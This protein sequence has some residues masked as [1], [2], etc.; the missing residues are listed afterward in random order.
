MHQ[1]QSGAVTQLKQFAVSTNNVCANEI[2]LIES[3][4]EDS[5]MGW[6][7]MVADAMTIEQLSMDGA[8]SLEGAQG[9]TCMCVP[10]VM[11]LT[12]LCNHCRNA[13]E[14]W[15]SDQR[16]AKCSRFGRRSGLVTLRTSRDS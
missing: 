7:F 16:V 10:R 1:I 13:G 12:R 15:T 6:L 11:P 3:V 9:L 5:E 8:H 2:V 14:D 4:Q